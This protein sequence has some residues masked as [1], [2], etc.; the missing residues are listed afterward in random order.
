MIS[1]KEIVEIFSYSKDEQEDCPYLARYM[2]RVSR[3]LPEI[4]KDKDKLRRFA[5]AGLFLTYRACNHSG[6][7]MTTNISDFPNESIHYKRLRTFNEYFGAEI[8]DTQHYLSLINFS[9]FH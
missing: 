5:L 6:S 7:K 3:K 8:K 2:K 9:F 4:E 1:E